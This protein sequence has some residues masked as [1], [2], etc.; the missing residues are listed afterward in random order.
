MGNCDHEEADTRIVIHVT[1]SLQNGAKVVQVCTVDTDV[2]VIITGIFYKLSSLHPST[3]IWIAFGMGKNFRFVHVNETCDSLGRRKSKALPYFHAFLG[4][5]TTSAFL[6]K[7]K[8]QLG[9]PGKLSLMLL[10]Q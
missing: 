9:K 2:I 1:H 10:R 8:N 7:G 5:D 3:D 6:S 4:C